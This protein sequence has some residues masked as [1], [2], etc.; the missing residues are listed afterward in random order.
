MS[1]SEPAAA[2]SP[3][4]LER[5]SDR[6][7]AALQ[8]LPSLPFLLGV[9]LGFLGC[10]MAGRMVSERPMFERFGR[11]FAPIQPQRFF[12]P[13]ASQLVAHIRHHTPP[14]KIPVIVGGASY[15]R[16]TGQN[17]DEVWTIELQ[18]R[19]GDRYVVFNFAIDQ[20]PITAFAAVAFEIIAREFPNALYVSN[21][22]PLSGAPW[23]GGDIY[24]Y[25]FWDAYYKQ[26]LPDSVGRSERIRTFAREQR[27]NPDTLEMHLR[28]WIDQFAYAC[29]LWTYVAYN[30]L[31]TVWTDEHWRDPHLPRRVQVEGSD[32]NIRQNQLAM[33]QNADYIRHSE[34][35]GRNASRDRFEQRKDGTWQPDTKAWDH[36]AEE[37]RNLFPAELRPRC[38]VVFLRGNPFFMQT[39]T[40]EDRARTELQ[41]QLGQRNLEQEGYRVVQLRAADFTADDFLDGGHYVASGGVK[42]AAAVADRIKTVNRD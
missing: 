36:L 33:R 28:T 30:H 11:F 22:N 38:F 2:V 18:R 26:L 24:G 21:G 4:R 42:I 35:H 27:R 34:E 32:P 31:F 5:W 10:A 14:G 15:F 16:G 19:L 13:T 41:Y 39:L 20:A 6:L 3:H 25:V 37:W 29:D 7:R 40:D 12:Y 9:I 8:R 17:P 1:H 23:D